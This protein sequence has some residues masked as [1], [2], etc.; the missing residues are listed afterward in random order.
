MNL[1][2]SLMGVQYYERDHS[3]RQGGVLVPQFP[4]VGMNYGPA[5]ATIH[6]VDRPVIS[7]CLI[8]MLGNTLFGKH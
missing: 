4:G 6:A 8:P 5:P 2:N 7:V 3:D 1:R